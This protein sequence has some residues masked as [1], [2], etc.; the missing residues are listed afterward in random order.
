M[1]EA[2]CLNSECQLHRWEEI[3]IISTERK[4][5]IGKCNF[6]FG[7]IEVTKQITEYEKRREKDKTLIST[8][9]L[10]LPPQKFKTQSL[11]FEI[12]QDFILY[13]KEK[14]Y[15]FHG[16]IHATEH[17]IIGIFPVEVTCDRWDIG[18]YSFPFHKQTEKPT[19]FIYDGYPGGVGISK[20]GFE[21][22][23][24]ILILAKESVEKCSCEMGCPSCIQS[25]KCGNNNKPLDKKGCIKLLKLISESI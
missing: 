20:K 3:E 10:Q 5:K 23:G 6:Y 13:L 25:P 22:I 24:K 18:G 9:Q 12:P 15:D 17:A 4:D 14:N 8:H 21:R 7:M 11:W 19:I 16:S 2:L 1:S